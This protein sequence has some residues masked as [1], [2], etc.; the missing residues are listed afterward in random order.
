MFA[1]WCSHSPA[2]AGLASGG[3][4]MS[5]LRYA[6]HIVFGSALAGFGLSFG[7]DVYRGMKK[8]WPFWLAI[9][10]LLSAFLGFYLCGLWFGRNHRRWY[11]GLLIRLGI[12]P[13][14]SACWAILAI[15]AYSADQ[16]INGGNILAL[17]SVP[18]NLVTGHLPFDQIT[19]Y[20]GEFA[21]I[22]LVCAVVLLVV[23]LTIGFLQRRRRRL[24][25]E[26]DIHN[27]QFF[28]EHGLITLREERLRD[29]QGNGYELDDV[30]LEQGELEFKVLGRRGKR[31]YLEFD[32]EG[33]YTN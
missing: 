1:M 11:R 31:A 23:G 29:D 19:A 8:D 20:S 26:A 33:K 24:A 27:E 3:L 10:V 9:V 12:I 21:E 13:L 15:L 22:G 5:V 14:A 7:R 18:I 16:T 17:L 2:P 32:E 25:W 30:F 28:E 4:S 6:P